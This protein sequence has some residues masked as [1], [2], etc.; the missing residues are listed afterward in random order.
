MNNLKISISFVSTYF[1]TI[2]LIWIVAFFFL[3][4][5]QVDETSTLSITKMQ[6]L[7]NTLWSGMIAGVIWGSIFRIARYFRRFLYNYLLTVLLSIFVNI[8]SAYLLIYSMYHM[9]D[10]FSMEGFP[11]TFSQL[12]DLYN[13]QLFYAILAYFF[14]VGALIEIFHDIDRK[15]GKGVLIKF[16]LGRYYKPKEEERI[17]MFM[18]LKSST[19]YAEKLGHFKYSRLIQDCFK[20]LTYSVKKNQAQIYQYIGDEVVLTWKMKDGLVEKRCVQLFIDFTETLE[21]KKAYYY[22]E[23]GML[24]IFKAGVHSGKVMVA[25][26]G[27]L[28]SEIAYHGD[29]INTAARI[30][31]LC[32]TYDSRL[33]ISLDLLTELKGYNGHMKQFKHLKQVV[34]KGKEIPIE[35]YTFNE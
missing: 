30:Q 21:R 16:L 28:K 22:S 18:D 29:A 19:Y 7:K 9:G 10:V 27:E 23:Y 31:G 12:L 25:E 13:S 14:I 17:F 32:N 11:E 24:P 4:V 5:F 8:S 35:I 3:T 1:I 26:I 33:L 6:N 15:F 2:V 34:L 20:D